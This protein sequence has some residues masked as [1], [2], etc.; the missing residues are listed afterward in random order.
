MIDTV[1]FLAR[2]GVA[3]FALLSSIYAT[4]LIVQPHVGSWYAVGCGFAV[5]VVVWHSSRAYVGEM[6]G[7]S[8]D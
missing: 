2:V 7:G 4:V 5:C 3:T 6:T 1:Q 8:D